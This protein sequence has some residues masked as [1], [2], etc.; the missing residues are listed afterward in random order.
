MALR[1]WAGPR[2]LVAYLALDR[3]PVEGATARGQ[4]LGA[5]M[6]HV[7]WSLP[8]RLSSTATFWPHEDNGMMGIIDITKDGRLFKATQQPRQDASRNGGPAHGSHVMT[9]SL[10]S[11]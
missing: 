6:P 10:A 11:L 5:C 3:V 8:R 7:R 4:P 2:Y 9:I 1:L